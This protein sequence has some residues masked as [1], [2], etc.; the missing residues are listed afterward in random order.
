M[1]KR[2]ERRLAALSNAGRRVKLDLFAEPSGQQPQNP[3]LLLGQYSDDELDEESSKKPNSAVEENSPS[4]HVDQEGLPIEGKEVDVNPIEDI[5][6]EKVEL[7]D[8]EKD[9]TPVDVHP[10][11]G[12][13]GEVD[14]TVSADKCKEVDSTKFISVTGS[15]AS[16]T[17]LIGDV[18]AGWRIVMHEE[19]NQYYYWNT[20]TGETSWEVPDVLAQTTPPICDQKAP[21]NE[22]VETASV[23]TN[24]VSSTL[25][26]GLDNASAALTLDGSIGANLI[27]Q[28][29][30][31]L[32]NGPQMDELVEGCKIESLKDKNWVTDA[33]ENGS[34]SNLSAANF[35]LGEKG[36]DLSTDL[37]RHCECL[38][39]RLK[40]LKG[41]GSR[42]Q[43]HDQMSKYI[44]EVDIRL[45][46]IK[47]LSSY[48]SALLPFW[49]HSQRQLKRLEDVINNEIYHLAVSAQM[50][51]D[52]EAT[53]NVSFEEKEKSWGSVGHHSNSDRCENNKKSE[54]ASV[55]TD[56]ENDS[57]D[58]PCENAYG[59]HISS[60]GSPNGNLEGGA[61]VGERANVTSCPDHEFHSG[62]DVM[63]VDMEVE[64]GV[65]VSIT[66]LG[67]DSST[68]FVAPA[69]QLS[70]PN[71]PAEH[72]T[73]TSGY[74]SSVPPPPE[75]DWIPPPPPDSDQ[76]PPPPPDSEQV[77]PPPPPDEPPESSYPLLP[78]YPE[79]HQPYPYTE[80]YNLP[81]PDPNFQY[82]GHTVTVPS[83]NLYGHADGSQVGVSHASLYY[84]TV[85]NTY[86]ETTPV[87]VSPVEPV[88]YYNLQDGSVPSLPDV[89]VESSCLHSESVPVGYDAFASDQVINVDKPAEAGQNLKLDVSVVVGETI[90][91][92]V[93]FTSNSI[94]AETPATTNVMENVSAASTNPGNAAAAVSVTTAAKVQ[95][96]VP[97]SKK[98]TVAV[99]PSL[100]SNKKVSS[101]VDKWKAAK[102]ELNENEEDE[103]ENAYEILEKKKQREI[104]EWH[105]KQ[106][107]SGEAKDNANFQPLGGDWRERV[108]RR[109][110]QAAKGAAK[111]PPEAP[112][113]ENQQPDLSELSM[114]LPS[115]WQAYWDEASKQVYYGNVITSETTWSKP[116]K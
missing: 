2:K 74:E 33:Y 101:L 106:I 89:R 84:E 31:I 78:S 50:D 34:Q 69:K 4:D 56:V 44:L 62:E 105:A 9:S 30:E 13:S 12:D 116:T 17:Q 110:A 109:R 75:E 40:S 97:R 36:M 38:L 32:C 63:D 115:G 14:A 8:M 95:S 93:G 25:G 15:G 43:C 46:D 107:A 86:V 42:L 27:N 82:Y 35:L 60:L 47:S 108:K 52:V 3:L 1:G 49:V 45:S 54:F 26:I 29:Q 24:E 70:L 68:K 87:M 104:E 48:G 73:L 39:E 21:A 61:V 85:A 59:R 102:E 114:G 10:E 58:D 88:A 80:Q 65:P 76:V 57:H 71:T 103:P 94:A 98:R 77:P 11:G 92:S 53:A 91:A 23:D 100:R 99:A 83:S 111:T 55:A 20:E 18:S 90:T 96:K 79:T 67:D 41:Y 51:D 81:Y 64:D 37:M 19:T 112:I 72:S 7:L 113:M 5:A 66:A 22:N 28:S 16:D 6:D